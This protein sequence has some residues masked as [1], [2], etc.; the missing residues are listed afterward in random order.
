MT[1]HVKGA[2]GA[3][4]ENSG[5]GC[6]NTPQDIMKAQQALNALGYRDYQNKAL[7][8]DGKWGERSSVAMGK[9]VA[10]AVVRGRTDTCKVLLEDYAALAAAPA[11]SDCPPGQ[12]RIAGA[13]APTFAAAA[14]AAKKSQPQLAKQVEQVVGEVGKAIPQAIVGTA[15]PAASVPAKAA[16]VKTA[17]MSTATTV[18]LAVGG[19]AAVGL[20]L[21]F[22]AKRAKP[23][24]PNLRKK[25]KKAEKAKV[26]KRAARAEAAK[27]V[28]AVVEKV[29]PRRKRKAKKAAKKVAKKKTKYGRRKGPGK[30]ITIKRAGREIRWGHGIAP[31]K[32]RR[33]GATKMSQYAAPEYFKYPIDS[34]KHVRAA[35]SYFPRFKKG[36]P[37]SVRRQIA[38]NI[39]KAKKR[40]GIGGEAVKPNR[41]HAR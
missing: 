28:E 38:D 14:E 36:L 12:V 18:A 21:F 2:L 34:A 32:Y 4:V 15:R 3:F 22:F 16:K 1:Y 9:Y 40:F 35:A 24:T 11:G 27:I 19:L 13:C 6:G 39:N 23:M 33:K 37:M 29:T 7:V 20:T 17:G 10:S 5:T 31:K 30:I 8:V 26:S 25:A 41:R